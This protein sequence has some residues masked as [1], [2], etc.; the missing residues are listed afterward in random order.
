MSKSFAIGSHRDVHATFV[1]NDKTGKWHVTYGNQNFVT[2][3]HGL[4]G[5]GSE[6]EARSFFTQVV[7]ELYRSGNL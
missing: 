4:V 5:F 1:K 6:K 7:D 3:T 2:T